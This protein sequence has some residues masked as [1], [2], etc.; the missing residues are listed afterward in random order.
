MN[1]Y[2]ELGIPIEYQSAERDFMEYENERWEEVTEPWSPLITLEQL[3]ARPDLEIEWYMPNWIPVG[4]KTILNG[5]PK[6]GKTILLLHLLRNIVQGTP[7]LGSQPVKSKVLY[8]TEQT[9]HEFKRQVAEVPGLLGDPNFFVLLAEES[10]KELFT[11]QNT[12]DFAAKML[13]LTKA[14]ILI[15][16]TFGGLAKLPPGGEN[17]SATI[18]N[19]I[20]QLNFLFKQRYLSVVLTHHNRKKSDDPKSQA[21]NLTLSS[22]RGS[23]AFVGG[24]GHI[25]MMN[26]ASGG[27]SREREV[28]FFG[29]YLHGEKMNLVLT[30]DGEYRNVKPGSFSNFIKVPR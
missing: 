10:P 2:E 4:G 27:Q 20:N 18:Q 3:K 14:H 5:E 26:D 12:L 11:W 19:H 25:I 1:N 17:D 9:E 22:A 6:C 16:D 28:A 7:F 24:G 13:N 8:F 15:F 21:G 23:S 30:T 29:R